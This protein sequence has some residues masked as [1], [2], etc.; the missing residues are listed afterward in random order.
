[1]LTHSSRSALT[2]AGM[3]VAGFVLSPFATAQSYVRDNSVGVG[4]TTYKAS[5]VVVAPSNAGPAPLSSL[6]SM[7]NMIARSKLETERPPLPAGPNL[8]TAGLAN[9]QTPPPPQGSETIPVGAQ[10]QS[11]TP[12]PSAFSA[13]SLRLMNSTTPNSVITTGKS[14]ILEPSVGIAGRSRFMTGNWFAAYSNNNGNAWTEI[15]PYST[16]AP[17]AGSPQFCC[18]QVV[19]YDPSRDMM[20]WYLQYVKSGSTS[21]DKGYQ[22]IAVFRDTRSGISSAGW[23]TYDL[24]PAALGG[25]ATGE[26]LDYPDMALSNDFLWIATNVFST[27][28]NTF[29]RSIVVRIPLDQLLAGGAVNMT[30]FSQSTVGTLKL[31]QGAKDVMYFA[32]HLTTSSMRIFIWREVVGAPVSVDRT[33]TSWIST[34]RGGHHC[35]TS[36]GVNWCGRSDERILAGALSWDQLTKQAQLWFFWNVGEGGSFAKPYIDAARF[37]ESG[38]V[39]ASR[40]LI[41]SSTLTYHYVAAAANERGDIALSVA[42]GNNTNVFP[43]SMVCVDD[44]FNGDPPAWGCLSTRLGTTGP[45]TDVWGDYLS[46]RPN[47]PGGHTWHAAGFTQQGGTSGTFTEPRSIVVGRQRDVREYIRWSNR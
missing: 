4:V 6:P 34:G 16:F 39:Y 11:L 30:Y 31:V 3:L 29:T 40:P 24:D 44:D 32:S 25:P 13:G 22:R 9:V 2:F 15:S 19:Q 37:R 35:T 14:N 41:Q 21:S 36:T 10:D 17:P 28:T 1:M 5:T 7:E 20:L 43:N 33:I 18:D 38:L 42:W 26:W 8:S 12:T 27:S 45:A 23:I 46:I 47:Y